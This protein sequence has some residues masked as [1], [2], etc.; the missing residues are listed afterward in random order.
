MK[1]KGQYPTVSAVS[2]ASTSSI[3]IFILTL[4]RRSHISFTTTMSVLED[5]RF[6]YKSDDFGNPLY[7]RVCWQKNDEVK[8]KPIG[9]LQQTGHD[10]LSL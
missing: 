7:A 8:P 1:W 3:L 4:P 9:R 6:Q 2:L 10:K 5:T